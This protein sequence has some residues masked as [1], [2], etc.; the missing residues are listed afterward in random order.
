M[1]NGPIQSWLDRLLQTAIVLAVTA[2]LL[3]VAVNWLQPLVPVL[4]VM[5][6]VIMLVY[7]L[8]TRR[9]RW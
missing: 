5:A 3:R 4:I 1:T 9:Q 6:I 8:V 2:F 7:W